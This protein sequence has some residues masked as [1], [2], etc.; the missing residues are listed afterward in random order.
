[1]PRISSSINHEP[2][3]SVTALA[4]WSAKRLRPGKVS[5]NTSMH[6]VYVERIT[7]S[8]NQASRVR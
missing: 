1:M 6:S 4:G 2:T 8:P 5:A 3:M 7:G